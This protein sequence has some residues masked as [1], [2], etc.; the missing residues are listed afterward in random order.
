MDEV[1]KVQIDK[2]INFSL[3]KSCIK[4]SLNERKLHE[5]RTKLVASHAQQDGAL[6]RQE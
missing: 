1:I 2:K 6:N 4:N 3:G 5:T